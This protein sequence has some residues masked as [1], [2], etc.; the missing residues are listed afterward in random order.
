MGPNGAGKTTLLLVV[1]ARMF[2]T[3]GDV[4]LLEEV[5]GAVDLADLKPADRLGE[6]APWPPTCRRGSPWLD[7]VMT[8]AWAVT[9]RWREQYE[10]ADRERAQRLLADWGIATSPGAPSA[11]CR[12]ASA[13]G[14]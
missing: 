10:D 5:M 13:S 4:E 8:G 12:R 9:G 11:R 7:V 3:S 1:S 2:P 14:R 6:R